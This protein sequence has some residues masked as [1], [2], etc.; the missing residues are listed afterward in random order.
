[1]P[2]TSPRTWTPRTKVTAS[3][4]NTEVAGNFNQLAS[5]PYCNLSAT[6]ATTMTNANTTYAVAFN[7]EIADADNMHSTSVNTSQITIGTAGLYEVHGGAG[8]AAQ[9]AATRFLVLFL[10]NGSAVR[11]TYTSIYVPP[12]AT[13]S[14]HFGAKASMYIRFTA[15]QYLELGVQCATAGVAT[16]TASTAEAFLQCRWLG[17]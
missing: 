2:W 5:P 8:I 9:T 3:I 17:P 4:L 16:A 7:T 6:A 13:V 14:G 1:M 11:Q 12:S 10:V 15:G